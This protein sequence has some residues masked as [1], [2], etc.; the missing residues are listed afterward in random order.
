MN[1][2]QSGITASKLSIPIKERFTNQLPR[3]VECTQLK[4]TINEHYFIVSNLFIG[5]SL[6][7]ETR[8]IDFVN[9]EVFPLTT[10]SASNALTDWGES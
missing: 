3:H 7:L 6:H 2:R 5:I 10:L 1:P 9:L 4:P 8:Q